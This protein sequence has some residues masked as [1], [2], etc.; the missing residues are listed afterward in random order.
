[1]A[2]EIFTTP[3]E[4]LKQTQVLHMA[5]TGGLLMMFGVLWFMVGADGGFDKGTILSKVLPIVLLGILLMSFNVYKM[6][7]RQAQE[8]K[9]ESIVTSP[10]VKVLWEGG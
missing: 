10:K 4:G 9:L 3:K 6:R 7:V 1:M 5:M 2:T 8:S